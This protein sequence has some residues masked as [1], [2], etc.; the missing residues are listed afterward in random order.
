MER[1]EA[2]RVTLGGKTWEDTA[3]SQPAS[4]R[5]VSVIKPANTLVLGVSDFE[6]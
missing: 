2:K 3:R 6:K 4:R 1:G 5:G